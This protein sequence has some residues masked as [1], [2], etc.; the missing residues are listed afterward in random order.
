MQKMFILGC[1]PTAVSPTI[2]SPSTRQKSGSQSQPVKPLPSKIGRKPNSSS[3]DTGEPPRP[4][5]P[6]PPR[7][8]PCP[9]AGGAPAA[10]GGVCCAPSASATSSEH[11]IV[12]IEPLLLPD[13]RGRPP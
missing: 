8:C 6:R 7:P 2:A 1:L 4:P 12:F 13:P 11:A 9:G 10:G 3:G 5:P